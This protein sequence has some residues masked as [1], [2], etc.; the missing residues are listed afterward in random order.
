MR[1]IIFGKCYQFSCEKEFE[2]MLA[3]SVGLYPDAG[4]T[5][6]NVEI[7]I[8]R[9]IDACKP[10]SVNPKI[11]KK[12]QNGMVNIF[13]SAEV[14]WSWSN[15]GSLRVE[16][17]IKNYSV[18]KMVIGKIWSME[19]PREVE[20]FEQILYELVLVPSVYFF[21]DIA[22][23]H[24]ACVS[25]AGEAYLL[26]G[27]G[28]VG[29]SSALLALK[30]CER[31]GFIS[32]D[33]S[34]VSGDAKTYGNMAWVKIYGYNCVGNDLKREILRDRGCLDSLHFEIRNWLNPTKVRRKVSP[35]RLYKCIES[36]DVKVSR[37]YYLVRED[38][39]DIVVS[40]I[41]L[42]DAVAM[43]ISVMSA[44]YNVFHNQLYW[45]HYNALAIGRKAMLTMEEVYDNWRTVLSGCFSF[46]DMYRVSI[47]FEMDHVE[48][49]SY[50]RDIV[51][52]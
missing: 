39:P 7:N 19:Y 42:E 27:T 4:L 17:A 8:G 5:D 48:Y 33:I 13:P 37:L 18:M 47:P 12:C 38:V 43:T 21:K 10:Y 9:A 40:R 32:D 23:V 22:P 28:G 2:S 50:I 6:T 24:A 11:H 44:E 31:V 34:V 36:G 26:A 3:E 29:K 35:D 16:V 25:S 14:Y 52:N 30:Q 20:T 41:S 51:I 46:I 49:Q 15:S 45:E 1:K